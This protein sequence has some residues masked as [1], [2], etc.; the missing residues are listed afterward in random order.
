M[1]VKEKAWCPALRRELKFHGLRLL[2]SLFKE[3]KACGQ[4]HS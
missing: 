4:T 1:E 3:F 2:C